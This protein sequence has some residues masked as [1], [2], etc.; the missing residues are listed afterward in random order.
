MSEQ[1][2]KMAFLIAEKKR[3]ESLRLRFGSNH[4]RD[5]TAK[6]FIMMPDQDNPR[7]GPNGEALPKLVPYATIDVVFNHKMLYANL[8]HPDPTSVVYDFTDPSRWCAFPYEGNI[9]PFYSIKSV[10]PS[11]TPREI[12]IK[13]QEILDTLR[14]ALEKVRAVEYNF[15]THFFDMTDEI[16][17]RLQMEEEYGFVKRVHSEKYK[18]FEQARNLWNER[19]RNQL[20]DGCQYRERLFYFKHADA[21]RIAEAIVAKCR[22]PELLGIDD[23]LNPWFAIGVKVSRLPASVVPTRVLLSVVSY[24]PQAVVR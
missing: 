14:T 7:V 8:Q 5:P 20:P 18:G 10:R 13:Q 9:K 17:R 19:I 3:I 22:S 21:S 6:M 4:Q 2:M 12:R 11:A 24:N 15:Y 23:F 1:Q 16:E